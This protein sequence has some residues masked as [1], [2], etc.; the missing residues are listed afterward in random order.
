M[1]TFLTGAKN[2]GFT[3]EQLQ[4]LTSA[5][6][7]GDVVG[8]AGATDNRVARFDGVTGKIIQ[9]SSATL[10]DSG[11]LS[12]S[13]VNVG[14]GS[15]NHLYSAAYTPTLTSVANVASSSVVGARYLRINNIT[16]ESFSI[17]VTPTAGA[18]L[19]TIGISLGVASNF[20]GVSDACG[21][22]SAI[23]SGAF[24]GGTIS[25]SIA[26]DYLVLSFISSGTGAHTF[27]GSAQYIVQ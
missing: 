27:Y 21:T 15:V 26:G 7:G 13:S 14:D 3:D 25:A 2:Y 10:D 24:V 22:A 4:L 1:T 17:V 16:T 5:V 18:T 20:T 12:T 8:P 23:V 19:T 11:N 6:V 9:S